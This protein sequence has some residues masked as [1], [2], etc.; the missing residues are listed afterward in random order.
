MLQLEQFRRQL[1]RAP[2]SRCTSSRTDDGAQSTTF[3]LAHIT[4]QQCRKS[5]HETVGIGL[6]GLAK[7]SLVRPRSITCPSRCSIALAYGP[8]EVRADTEIAI[9]RSRSLY[10][11]TGKPRSNA[12]RRAVWRHASG[13]TALSVG[14]VNCSRVS[15]AMSAPIRGDGGIDLIDVRQ[16]IYPFVGRA[17]LVSRPGG[18][19]PQR[20][21]RHG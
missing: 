7:S 13:P 3:G 10:R 19:P 18:W 15:M 14:N 20:T 6:V 16:L 1:G 17:H 9:T 2:A 8:T 21:F 11:S 5:L 4:S 12:P